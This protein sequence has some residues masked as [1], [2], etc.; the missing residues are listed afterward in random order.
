[1]IY[2]T[3][4]LEET[5]ELLKKCF[6]WPNDVFRVKEQERATEMLRD[7][8]ENEIKNLKTLIRR[9]QKQLEDMVNDKRYKFKLMFV[10]LL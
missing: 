4:H 10:V 2:P 5:F 1:M 6:K 9:Q 8:Y 3:L 7:R